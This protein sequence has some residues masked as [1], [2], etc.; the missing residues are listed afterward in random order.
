MHDVFWSEMAKWNEQIPGALMF[1]FPVCKCEDWA[2]CVIKCI[3]NTIPEISG[4]FLIKVRIYA[5]VQKF[6]VC[7]LFLM[8]L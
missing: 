6:M 5:T 2:R 8:F 3:C 1:V 4:V 7:K